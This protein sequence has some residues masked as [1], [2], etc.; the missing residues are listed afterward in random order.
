MNQLLTKQLKIL[1]LDQ[2]GKVGGAELSLLDVVAPYREHCTVCLFEDGLFRHY[3]E[4]RQIPVHVLSSPA[5]SVKKKFGLIQNLGSL[6][7]VIPLVQQVARLSHGYDV[8]YANTAKSFVVAAM[9]SALSHRPLIYHLRDIFSSEHFS[10]FN[11]F[12]MVTLANCFAK[13]VIANSEATQSAFVA[14]G[15]K[16][17]LTAVVYNGFQPEIYQSSALKTLSVREELGLTQQFVVGHFSR[18][19]P[20]KGQHILIAALKH[21][22]E[23]VIALFVGDAL[24]GEKAYVK[25]LHHQVAELG[26]ENRVRF[27]GFRCDIPQLMQACDLVAHTSIAPEPFGRVIIEAMLCA[28]PV[29]AAQDGGAMELVHHDKTGWLCLPSDPQKLADII[30]NCRNNPQQAKTIAQQAQNEASQRFHLDT[31]NQQIAQLLDRFPKKG[32]VKRRLA[33]AIMN[34]SH[35]QT[36]A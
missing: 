33:D 35:P 3:L 20:W 26:L 27:I 29:V 6:R 22:S 36:I 25:Q 21:C 12:V 18:L 9:A 1:F 4:E 17:K 15:G 16:K 19:S 2:S 13:L 7:Q 34:R 28:R 30:M 32:S 5:F 14:A 10:R 11:L 8:I 31:I 23:D 24:F